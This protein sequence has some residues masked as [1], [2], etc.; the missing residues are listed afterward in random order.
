MS[1][2]MI[3]LKDIL[4]ESTKVELHKVITDKTESAFMTEEQWNSKWDTIQETSSIDSKLANF[5]SGKGQLKTSNIDA[6]IVG[7][8]DEDKLHES[9]PAWMA[10]LMVG[11]IIY[12]AIHF[13]AVS[14]PEQ[15]KKLQDFVRKLDPTKPYRK[16]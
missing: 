3:K 8:V 4:S 12:R 11:K 1:N 6:A 13:W 10:A 7:E 9:R 2:K 16:P 14:N 15:V 5:K